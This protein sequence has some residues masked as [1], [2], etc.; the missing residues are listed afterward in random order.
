MRVAD[1]METDVEIADAR[2]AAEDAWQIMRQHDLAMLVVTQG[3]EVAGVVTREQLGG[4]HGRE[5]REDRHLEAFLPAAPVTLTPECSTQHAAALLDGSTCGC[6]PVLDRG[7]L[8][9]VVTVAGL[10][11][12]MG[13]AARARRA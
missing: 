3:A 11:R 12:R 13:A 9:G 1:L 7:H 8:V 2:L 5:N 4:P 6:V 10:L